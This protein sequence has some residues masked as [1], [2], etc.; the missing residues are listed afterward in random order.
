MDA[1]QLVHF[2]VLLQLV[3]ANS[4]SS[5]LGIEAEAFPD[6]HPGRAHDLL[7]IGIAASNVHR[8]KQRSCID[9]LSCL[10]LFGY[11]LQWL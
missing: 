6:L 4:V 8:K 5:I 2:L 7:H 11:S 9:K 10:V 3:T 1:V